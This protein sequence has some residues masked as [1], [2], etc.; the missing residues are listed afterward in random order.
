MGHTTDT[1]YMAHTRH[2]HSTHTV[3]IIFTCHTNSTYGTQLIQHSQHK[4]RSHKAHIHKAHTTHSAYDTKRVCWNVCTIYIYRPCVCCVC[5]C[6]TWPLHGTHVVC[7]RAHRCTPFSHHIAHSILLLCDEPNYGTQHTQSDTAHISYRVNNH[8][9]QIEWKTAHSAHK[10]EKRYTV[11]IHHTRCLA[12]RFLRVYVM[13]QWSVICDLLP[14]TATVPQK[15]RNP[16]KCKLWFREV[17]KWQVRTAQGAEQSC[18]MPPNVVVHKGTVHGHH[19]HEAH[20]TLHPITLRH[21]ISHHMTVHIKRVF[22]VHR[23]GSCCARSYWP[24][25]CGQHIYRTDKTAAATR[26]SRKIKKHTQ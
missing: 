12:R 13:W 18:S 10:S 17:H 16:H 21:I 15:T 26:C 8:T 22:G 1:Q 3:H 5:V 19:P 11:H 4:A 2:A 20:I 7:V 24:R 9:V 6:A 25:L 14:Y 23:A